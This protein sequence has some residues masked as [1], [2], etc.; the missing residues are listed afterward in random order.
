MGHPEEFSELR[1]GH[2]PSRNRARNNLKREAREAREARGQTERFPILFEKTSF[3]LDDWRFLE[4][5]KLPVCPQFP[6]FPL[7]NCPLEEGEE[8]VSGYKLV[9]RF[10]GTAYESSILVSR[11]R[12]TPY[13]IP[14]VFDSYIEA[15]RVVS[16]CGQN[17]R[18]VI[19]PASFQTPLFVLG[20]K[21]YPCPAKDEPVIRTYYGSYT[22]L[23]IAQEHP[24]LSNTGKMCHHIW[25]A[26][27]AHRNDYQCACYGVK[28]VAIR[29]H[30]CQFRAGKMCHHVWCAWEAHSSDDYQC[31]QS[32]SPA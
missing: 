31:Q 7:R 2:P 6:Q 16:H 24:C 12:G 3:A 8:E 18:V 32:T 29:E 10:T 20:N 30:P 19:V 9:N 5:G 26:R 25:C 4:W 17:Y 14:D 23:V 11:L 13:P 21:V 22:K 15:C 1:G 27:K 28:R